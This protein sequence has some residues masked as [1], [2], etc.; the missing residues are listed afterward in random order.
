MRYVLM[1]IVAIVMAIGLFS[2]KQKAAEVL[3]T[4]QKIPS[5]EGIK[6]EIF[7]NAFFNPNNILKPNAAL[8][9]S[10]KDIIKN[11]VELFLS[12]TKYVFLCGYDYRFFYFTD[13]DSLFEMRSVNSECEVFDY[14]PEKANAKLMFY[15]RKLEKAPT[16]YIY[17]IK[18]PVSMKV[19]SIKTVLKKRGFYPFFADPE[20]ELNRYPRLNFSCYTSTPIKED[21]DEKT[22]SRVENFNRIK[23]LMKFKYIIKKIKKIYSIVYQ[24]DV[25]FNVYG[26]TKSEYHH[27]GYVNLYFKVGTKLDD[28][29]SFLKKEGVDNIF[30]DEKDFYCIQIADTSSSTENVKRRLARCKFIKQVSDY[31]G[32][33]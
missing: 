17:D 25:F 19:S 20:G 11:D 18:I 27:Q 30:I 21:S 4:T 16:H 31:T 1:S 12:Q 24:S 5:A 9:I 26:P 3:I 8:L 7:M 28:I 29:K 13:S 2:C 32:K 15:I 6:Y 33:K 10:N 14:Q 23:S 22:L